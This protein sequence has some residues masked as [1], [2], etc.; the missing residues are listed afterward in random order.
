MN[1]TLVLLAV[2]AKRARIGLGAHDVYV[3][4]AGGLRVR[5]P[6]ADLGVAAAMASAYRDRA[7][8]PGTVLI[9]EVGLSGEVRR[10]S[11]L[12]ARVAEARSL[13]FTRAIVPKAS[14][15]DVEG[16]GIAV[17]GVATIRE[18]LAK[19]ALSD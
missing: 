5:E 15:G 6:A 4:L 13:G 18:A 11:R 3:S 16:N 17:E 19:I 12:S 2:L 10:V 1:R 9:G 14:L 8:Q 7:P